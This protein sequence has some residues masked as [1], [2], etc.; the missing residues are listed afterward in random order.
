MGFL[1]DPPAPEPYPLPAGLH[2]TPTHLLDLRADSEI[3]NDLL[4]MSPVS[5]EKNIWFFWHAGYEQMHPCSK[6]NV[7]AWYR[8]FSKQGWTIRVTDYLPDSPMNIANFLDVNDGETFPRA[9]A[10]GT[11]DGRYALYRTSEFLRWPLLLK[12][13]GVWADT[14]MIPIGD[15]DRLWNQ[16]IGDPDARFKLISYNAGGTESYRLTSYF[17]ASG[18]DNPL[19]S[20]CQRL[21]LEIW[22][23]DG[24]KNNS[25]G[26]HASPLLKG[27]PLMGENENLPEDLRKVE[28]DYD[29][30]GQVMTMVMGL[31]DEEE[32]WNGPQ[33]VAEHVWALD[34]WEGSFLY[35][36][37]T[38]RDGRK[39]F[40]LMSFLLPKDGE[41][42]SAKQE[43]AREIVEGSLQRSF[44]FK[45]AH[46]LVVE[47]LGDSLGSLW[48]KH[49]GSDN[50]PGTY[51]HWLRH[52][53]VYWNQNEIPLSLNFKAI[54]PTKKGRLLKEN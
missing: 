9:F 49:E 8:R 23:A 19:F 3:D 45:L 14:G 20:R 36:K 53:T 27:I 43:Q 22:A 6:R 54:E 50:V 30:L 39:A 15:M 51:A 35:N 13:G 1:P 16:T 40:E 44:G 46:G 21:L 52:G 42:E 48:R 26:M 10:E 7:R 37:V 33:Y 31:V 2:V 32:K 28:T 4:R 5:S 24:G 41:E 47:V 11:L 17:F 18:R 29:M 34:Y 38:A 12:Y 25:N